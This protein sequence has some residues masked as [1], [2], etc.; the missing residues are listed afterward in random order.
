MSGDNVVTGCFDSDVLIDYFDGIATA[1]EELSHYDRVLI[2][3][4]TWME[5]LVGAPTDT[6]RRIREDFLRQFAVIELDEAVA[7]EAIT[8]RQEYKL[9][10]PDAIIWASARLNNALL[11]TRNARDFDRGEPGVRI[12]YRL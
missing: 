9:K 7:R 8:L 12:P 5:V 3:R 2:S 10:L 6:L 11:I 1:G 4:I